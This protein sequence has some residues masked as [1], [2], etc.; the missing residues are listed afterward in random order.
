MWRSSQMPGPRQSVIRDINSSRP[1]NGPDIPSARFLARRLVILASEDIGNADPHALPLAVA[2]MQACEFVG[3]PECQLTL[4]QAVAYLACAPKSNAA[5]VAIG[6]ARRDVREGR[7]LPVPRHLQ[8]S[9]YPGAKRLGHGEGYEYAHNAAGGI[10][11]IVTRSGT[12]Q[13]RG[14]AFEFLRDGALNARNFFAPQKDTLKRNQF[15]GS[16]GGPIL[17]DRMFYFGTYQGT[18]I[19]SEA[20]GRVAFVPTAAER[21]GDF[22]ALSTQL[23]D[24][25]TRQPFPNNQIPADR[26]I[27]VAKYFLGWI[28]QPNRAGRELN[29]VGTEQVGRCD[30]DSWC[31]VVPDDAGSTSG[32]CQPLVGLGASCH[33]AGQCYSMACDEV[34]IPAAP[35]LCDERAAPRHWR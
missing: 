16:V 19:R 2:A 31:E 34:C 27:P 25:I 3:L 13:I 1:R 11:N 20:A 17:R 8:D 5:T 21:A 12:N 32:T 24:P 22:S 7:L 28:P 30:D 26:I 15:G 10:V 29:F 18:R 6:E 33:S 14:S 23:V 4:A 35:W 9:H